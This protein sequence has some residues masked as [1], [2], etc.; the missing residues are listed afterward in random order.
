MNP[1]FSFTTGWNVLLNNLIISSTVL[2]FT[3]ELP[4]HTCVFLIMT[5]HYEDDM[6]VLL[7][8]VHN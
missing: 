6:Y 8:T 5:W 3:L 7:S 2:V 4:V 1:I